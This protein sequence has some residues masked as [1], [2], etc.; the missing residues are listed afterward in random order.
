MEKALTF[1]KNDFSG[2]MNRLDDSTK[3]K[4]NEVPLLVNARNRYNVIEPILVPALVSAGLPTGLYQGIYAAGSIVVVFIA[5]KAYYKDYNNAASNFTQVAGLLMSTTAATIHLSFVAISN[6]NFARKAGTSPN[7]AITLGAS[8]ATSPQ[9]AVVQDGINQPW[10]INA[11]GTARITQNYNQWSLANREYVPIGL[12][13]AFSDAVL[14]VVSSNGQK[15]YRS[16]TGRPLD[17]VVAVDSAA[18]KVADAE[19]TS[20]AVTYGTITCIKALNTN[21]SG[22]F[23]STAYNSFLVIPDTNN[24]IFGEPTFTN[25]PLFTTGPLNQFSFIELLGDNAFIDFSGI[26]SFN[27]V[28][29][30]K[31]EGQ[32]SPFSAKISPLLAGVIQSAT[33]T[34]NFDDYALFALKTVYGNAIIFY[35]TLTQT[36]VNIDKFVS[37]SNIKQFAEVKLTASRH[38][39]YLTA[40]GI[41]EYYKGTSYARAGIYIG[42]FVSGDNFIQHK[43]DKL[44]LVFT[45]PIQLGLV[46]VSIFV[47]AARGKTYSTYISAYVDAQSANREFPFGAASKDRVRAIDIDIAREAT[48]HKLGMYIEWAFNVKLLSAEMVTLTEINTEQQAISLVEGATVIPI[49]DGFYFNG[50][51]LADFANVILGAEIILRGTNIETITTIRIG[52]CI[53]P[54]V[55]RA[56]DGLVITVTPAFITCRDSTDDDRSVVLV[57]IDDVVIILDDPITIKGR[58]IW[59][60]NKEFEIPDPIPDG[61]SQ[62]CSLCRETLQLSWTGPATAWNPSGEH[63]L[64]VSKAEN[65]ACYWMLEDWNGY[66]ATVQTNTLNQVTVTASSANPD[67]QFSVTFSGPMVNPCPTGLFPVVSGD[68]LT[69]VSVVEL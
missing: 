37:L 30:L 25:T 3:V 40:S 31:R 42:D 8:I 68:A 54:V 29:Q 26:R 50:V 22:I 62:V 57:T 12:Q 52:D 33:A 44:S 60:K 56:G 69:S 16:V 58:Y 18:D 14:Y 11:D 59:H 5:G 46:D 63:S 41:Y 17:F 61:I 15:I 48:G 38:L 13:M 49:M 65:D 39:F 23:V 28:L 53:I 21:P 35:D 64:Q 66:S 27:A 7:S 43:P 1:I 10:I 55:Y 2:G 9:C 19:L 20:H 24:L 36:W 4:A 34:V 47:D 51:K 32:N 67:D 6:N 45:D